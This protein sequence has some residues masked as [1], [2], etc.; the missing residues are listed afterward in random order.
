MTDAMRVLSIRQ[1]WAHL[2]VT[3][4]KRIE[5]RTWTTDYRGPLLIHAGRRWADEP[6]ETIEKCFNVKIP[7]D[8]SRGGIVGIGALVD[9]VE[10]SEDGYFSDRR[11]DQRAARLSLL[12]TH[13]LVKTQAQEFVLRPVELVCLWRRN[14]EKQAM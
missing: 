12:A 10:Q 2:I 5:N 9:V 3:G 8:L 14:R 1:P 6:V 4:Q 13:L 11:F 7:R